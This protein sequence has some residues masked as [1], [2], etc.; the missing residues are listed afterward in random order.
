MS[1]PNV[2]INF[3]QTGATVI[4]RGER[5]IAA[6]VLNGETQEVHELNNIK[7]AVG[8]DQ[9]TDK[10]KE[11][12]QLAFLGYIKPPKKVIIVFRGSEGEDYNQ[13]QEILESLKLK[14]KW[15]RLL[16]MGNLSYIMMEKRL[17]LQ[18]ESITSP[19][20]HKIKENPLRR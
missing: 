13:A 8:I 10:Q 9:L 15:M 11:Y 5:G 7:D 12:L 4:Q 17:K 18:E 3:K 16:E 14:S 2:M 1:L 20:P 6:L 19:Q